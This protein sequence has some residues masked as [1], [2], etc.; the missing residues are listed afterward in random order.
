[1]CFTLIGLCLTLLIFHIYI[2]FKTQ[3]GVIETALAS[4]LSYHL[5]PPTVEYMKIMMHINKKT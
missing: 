2:F 3:P 1:M 4:G 5:S